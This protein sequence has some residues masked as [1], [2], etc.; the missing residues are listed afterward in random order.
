MPQRTEARIS[1]PEVRVDRRTLA[2]SFEVAKGGILVLAWLRPG[3]RY[4]WRAALFPVARSDERERVARD[5]CGAQVF[6]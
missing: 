2:F 6:A 3:G 1:V 5:R 4:A